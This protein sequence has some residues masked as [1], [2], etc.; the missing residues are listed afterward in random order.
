MIATFALGL[1][2]SIEFAAFSIFFAVGLGLFAI[3]LL[4]LKAINALSE[5]TSGG[6][7]VIHN[8]IESFATK[9][10]AKIIG[11][12]IAIS[13]ELLV[14][15][16]LFAA[17]LGLFLTSMLALKGVLEVAKK[18]QDSKVSFKDIYSYST[19]ALYTLT[20]GENKSSITGADLLEATKNCGKLA[21]LAIEMAAYIVPMAGAFIAMVSVFDSL[22]K[23]QEASDKIGGKENVDNLLGSVGII[24]KSMSESVESFKGMSAKAITAIGS[25]VKDVA[26]S[27]GML[28]DTMIKIKDGIKE[29]E[30]EGATNKIKLMCENLFGDGVNDGDNFTLTKLFKTLSNS[31]LKKLR[32]DSTE[33]LIPLT[34]SI[35]LMG[36]VII[37][38]ADDKL[39]SEEKI[40]LG[41]Q[42]FERIS[43]IFSYFGDLCKG[44]TKGGSSKFAQFIGNESALS[45]LNNII[46]DNFLG[47]VD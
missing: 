33:A 35:S 39:F 5:N 23:L 21:I 8:I 17:G 47:G 37:K 12:G 25:L 15:S 30:I 41:T 45:S 29:E 31:S 40:N 36:D 38:F 22:I 1:V 18:L 9:E 46:K 24:F 4:E 10:N 42:N 13:A 28:A 11:L 43:K 34:E 7:E 20:T 44:L 14:F 3:S 32:K 19:G 27:I 2:V 6:V 16:V 26:E